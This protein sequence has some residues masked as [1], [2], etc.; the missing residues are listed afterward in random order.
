MTTPGNQTTTR[1]YEPA[2]NVD[3]ETDPL[4]LTWRFHFDADNSAVGR[5]FDRCE[6]LINLSFQK[7]PRKPGHVRLALAPVVRSVYISSGTGP[8]RVSPVLERI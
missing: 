4:R 1:H 7:I 6:N 2:G 8:E 5:T 3:S